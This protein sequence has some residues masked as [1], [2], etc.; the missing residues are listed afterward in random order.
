MGPYEI[1][2]IRLLDYDAKNK[3]SLGICLEMEGCKTF[4]VA[5]EIKSNHP[6][7][8]VEGVTKLAHLLQRAIAKAYGK[9]ELYDRHR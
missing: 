7:R 5:K 8:I 1:G 6:E 4:C 3:W 9:G 2:T